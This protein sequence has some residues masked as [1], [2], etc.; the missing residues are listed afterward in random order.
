MNREILIQQ[1]SQGFSTWKLAEL[2]NTTQPNIRYWLKKYNLQTLRKT[3]DEN[4]MKL[5]PKCEVSKPKSEFYKSVKSS[6]YCKSCIVVSN[7]QRQRSTKQLAVDYKG[8]KCCKCGYNK[9]IAALEFHHTDPSTKDKD[10]FNQR[11]GL[12]DDLK[13]EL[14]KCVLLCANC[15]R[16]EHHLLTTNI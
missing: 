3:N 4:N 15:H 9:C 14:D 16:E 12:T 6:S 1:I 11:G 10:Y 2:N 13:I 7:R 8:G 5:C